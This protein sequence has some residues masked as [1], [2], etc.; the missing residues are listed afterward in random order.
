MRDVLIIGGGPAGLAAAIYTARA[1]YVTTVLERLAPGGQAME[2]YRIDNYPGFRNVSGVELAQDLEQHARSAGTE[3]RIEDAQSLVQTDKGWEV[4]TSSG[5]YQTRTVI[6]ATGARRRKLGVP[7][8]EELAGRGVSYCAACDGNF[9][10][11]RSVA[12]VGGGNSAVGDAAELSKICR[13]VR[14]ICRGSEVHAPFSGGVELGTLPNVTLMTD[15]VVER[16][17]GE[18]KVQSV[19]TKNRKTGKTEV[20]P[21]DGVFIAIGMLP[22]SGLLDG[23]LPLENGFAVTG[24]RGVTPRPGLFVAGDLRKKDLH[25]IV[26]AMS[27]G[28]NAAY[29]AQK[30]LHAA[31]DEG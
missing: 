7:G 30:Y 20:F 4:H 22:N 23:L 21:M 6:L 2:T 12:V 14:V 16:I 10:R 1:G 31:G 3:I 26:T 19:R 28:A 17:E 11:G 5:V 27:D 9:F 24:E 29:A 13:D 15:T 18:G 8:E 25:Q